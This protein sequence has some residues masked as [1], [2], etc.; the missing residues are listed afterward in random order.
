[1]TDAAVLE[2]LRK[3][4]LGS[5]ALELQQKIES[6]RGSTREKTTREKLEDDDNLNR[7][8]R[9][10][11]TKSS[12]GSYGYDRDAA[13]PIIQWG[14]P[15]TNLS[16]QSIPTATATATATGATATS[17]VAM[18]AEEARVYL[19]AFVSVQLWVLSLPD[20]DGT[21]GGTLGTRCA[22]NPI[23]RAHALLKEDNKELSLQS[24]M[25]ELAKP[26]VYT[27]PRS[28][29]KDAMA[30]S[31]LYTL[32]PS[33][34]NELLA[35]S[36]AL[37]VHTYCELIE[38]GMESTAHSL[39]DAFRPIY[40]VIYNDEYRD[41]HNCA[42][43]E[44]MMRLN[45]HNSQHMEALAN[46]KTILVQVA[47][48]QFRRDEYKAQ[49]TING[50]TLDAQQMQARDHK[51]AEYDRHI[52]QLKSKYGELS[53]KASSA[54]DKM[55]DLP[56][57]R[58]ARAVRWQLNLSTTTYAMLCS[59]LNSGA[60][61]S[62]LAMSSLLQTKCELHVERRDPL[63]FI[64]SC[65]LD[66]INSKTKLDLNNVD[67]NW[68]APVPRWKDYKESKLPFPKFK[69]Q[70]E[71]EN[72]EDAAND[73]QLVEF[74]RALLVNG[75]RRLEAL[76]RK[77]EYD[78]LSPHAQKRLKE[79][80]WQIKRSADPFKPS[81]LMTTLCS[82]SKIGPIRR[83]NNKR[84]SL[85][86]SRSGTTSATSTITDVASIWGE[87]SIGLVCAKL[88]GPDG[89]RIAVGCDD[90]AVRIWSS[91]D[92]TGKTGEPLQVL[93]GHKNGF[94][95]FD[96]DWGRDGRSLLSAGG[97]GSVRLWD[98]MV[99][100]PFGEV[101]SPSTGNNAMSNKK[102]GMDDLIPGFSKESDKF[103]SGAA[104]AVYRGHA[105]N[106][107]VW[108]VAFAPSG[109]YF[110]SAGADG[111]ARLWTT[112]RSVPVRLFA[113]HTSC[114]VNCVEWHPNCNYIITGSDDKTSRL[115]DI[116]SGRTVRL[117]T[118]FTSGVS[119]VQIDPSGRH[120]AVADFSGSVHL[121]DLGTGKKMTEL[122]HKKPD[123][124][125]RSMSS[126]TNKF[127]IHTLKF[128]ACGSVLASGGDDCCVR[129][130]DVRSDSVTSRAWCETP[131]HSFATQQTMLL[132]LYY[133][134]RN[135]L[136]AAGKYMS[137]V[138]VVA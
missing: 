72:E 13:W 10:L 92:T 54:F 71:Y 96:L 91:A 117:L 38:V 83:S 133:T 135:L 49:T 46:L 34:K 14:V 52:G 74:N 50:E 3:K 97:D 86:S 89:R 68:A 119:T 87:A 8:Q 127:A 27:D 57:L 9:S 121:W 48:L 32:P 41:L 138:P 37:L 36:F 16:T 123:Q 106:A 25:N 130:W 67:I 110:A 101:A 45:S 11:L 126:L 78:V 22:L 15:D 116:Q 77:R 20:D 19:D 124:S 23:H 82:N 120:A 65:I 85:S 64:P 76:E 43:T 79:G 81:V 98:T 5:A 2:Y 103:A 131:L 7:I 61:Q 21:T 95:V 111:T 51:I 26:T 136:L 28:S 4:G 88:C 12:G 35:V 104:L 122:R 17:A 69:L 66:G 108:S 99:V 47:S 125:H 29:S 63:P 6:D 115:W 128:S 44:D 90:A 129:I 100:G 1:M 94:P 73:K 80:D 107:P 24:V 18:G 102:D 114:N 118:G 70:E 33:P 75:F 93:L 59:F 42:T 137:P 39:R 113:G 105:P 53:Q 62:L 30:S 31:V 132:D 60:D 134:K 109:Y 112:D 55:H 58:R 84:I 56:F 40:D